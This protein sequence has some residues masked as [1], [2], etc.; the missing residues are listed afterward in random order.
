M[1]WLASGV[2]AWAIFALLGLGLYGSALD[3]PFHYDDRHSVQYNHH[4]RSLGNLPAFFTDPATFSSSASGYM[5]RPLLLATYAAN[6]AVAGLDVRLLRLVNLGLHVGCAGLVYLL[7]RRLVASAGAGWAA[8]LLM[9]LHP[10]HAEPVNY[11]S[12]RS[13]LLV[14]CLYLGALGLLVARRHVSSA[15]V[16]AAALLSKSVAITFPVVALASGRRQ[17][18]PRAFLTALAALSGAYL[19]V[20]WA[21]RFLASSAGKAPRGLLVNAWTQAKSFAYYLWLFASPARLT[22]EHAFTESA[23]A[24]AASWAGLALVASLVYWAWRGRRHAAGQ[25]I[26]YFLIVLL[27]VALVPLN[28]MVAERRMYLATPGLILAAAWAWRLW[29]GRC[30]RAA[31]LAGV[32]WCAL[33]AVLC[34]QRSHVWGDDVRLWEEAVRRSPGMHRA[35]LNLALA[36]EAR[37]ARGPAMEQLQEGLRLRPDFAD[38]WVLLGNIR[39][40]QGDLAGAEEAYRRALALDGGLAG[41]YHNLANVVRDRGGSAEEVIALY[42]EALGR[43]PHLARARNN[44]GQAYEGAGRLADALREYELAVRDPA[45]WEGPGDP[46]LG[47]TWY[48]L[49]WA[50]ERLGEPARAAQAYRRAHALLAPLAADPRYQAFAEEA[51]QGWLRLEGGMP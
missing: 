7:A 12:A 6:Y 35:R 31:R 41:A 20:I 3:N 8:G 51:R 14:T 32:A 23:P 38:G 25:G 43:D 26:A 30:G 42:L 16:Y 21:N 1:R 24:A 5:Y 4:I 19:A 17:R 40:D 15:L 48:N 47:G 28:T 22:V 9:L 34:L 13:D 2:A 39:S 49:A 10:L 50:A 45:D 46:E 11:I 37:G 36:Y 33:A 29:E 18:H 27:P 44:L